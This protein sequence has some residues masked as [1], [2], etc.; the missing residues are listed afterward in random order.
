MMDAFHDRFAELF[1]ANYDRLFRYL[2]R[3]GG[4]PELAGDVVQE[5]FV[6]LYRRGSLPDDPEAWLLS[7]AMNLFRNARSQRSRRRR[8][9]TVERGQRAVGDSPP[10]PDQA[11]E[12]GQ[13]SAR[14]RAVLDRLQERERQLLLLRAE[15]YG[16]REIAR[17]LEL[18]EASVGT[19]LARAKQSFRDLYTDSAY[20]SRH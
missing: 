16:Y 14:V 12:A 7:V 19:L 13:T 11:A 9:L 6:R 20:A 3:Q 5:A 2:D 10:V 1:R 18:N 4:D 8:L 17:A 15:G